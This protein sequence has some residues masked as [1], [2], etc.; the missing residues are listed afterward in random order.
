MAVTLQQFV[1]DLRECGI[2]SPDALRGTAT[3]AKSV[4]TMAAGLV[5]SGM[6]TPFQAKNALQGKTASLVL[7]NYL[8]LDLIG[9]GGMGKVFKAK[10]RLMDRIVALKLLNLERTEAS[11]NL[12]RFR[13]E[14]KT[15]ASLNHPNI[16]TAFDADQ[17]GSRLFLVM[18]FVDGSDLSKLVRIHERLAPRTALEYLIH[19]ARGLEFAHAKG[20][21]HRDV[22]PAN[23]LLTPDGN[24]KVLDLGLAKVR[25]ESVSLMPTELTNSGA[26]IGT[27]DFMAPEQASDPRTADERVDIYSLGCTLFYLLT[28]EVLYGGDSIVQKL[29]AHR[30]RPAPELSELL[31]GIPDSINRAYLRMV[32]KVP[33]D[34]YQSMR[35]VRE[36]LEE[37][38]KTLGKETTLLPLLK[39]GES[40]HASRLS[41]RSSRRSTEETLIVEESGH[42]PKVGNKADRTR[43]GT[44]LGSGLLLTLLVAGGGY[45]FF[46]HSPEVDGDAHTVQPPHPPGTMNI[47]KPPPALSSPGDSPPLPTPQETDATRSFAYSV[48]EKMG[49]VRID[50]DGQSRMVTEAKHLPSAPFD[51]HSVSLDRKV[52][53][54]DRF[55]ESWPT[56]PKLNFV[57]LTG[58]DIDRS[59]LNLSKQPMLK[60]LFLGETNISDGTLLE[61]TRLPNLALLGLA[62]SQVTDRGLVA[63]KQMNHLV[64]LGID[65]HQLTPESIGHLENLPDLMEIHLIGTEVTDGHLSLIERLKLVKTLTLVKTSTTVSGMDKLRQEKPNL[66]IQVEP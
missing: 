12:E 10:H 16:V 62:D 63:L 54:D 2:V 5:K 66:I 42:R 55:I 9:E 20:I 51:I 14:V 43:S 19:A 4:E 33:D 32:A 6:L 52:G 35:E 34:R 11:E 39:T 17:S 38:R 26:L 53:V 37:I 21:I 24:V 48:L 57:D 41:S 36:D 60:N 28:G 15:A 58:A 7:G 65:G 1:R 13:R 8:L 61:L 40:A 49:T 64:V 31:R 44:L 59:V 47:R 56:L 46:S 25:A 23:L 29:L 22:K 18:E 30:E 50:V 3:Q 27:V 45:W